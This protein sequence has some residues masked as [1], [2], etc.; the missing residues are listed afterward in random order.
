MIPQ[1]KFE[2]KTKRGTV[3]H[4]NIPLNNSSKKVKGIEN[5]DEEN[6]NSVKKT[7]ILHNSESSSHKSNS[8]AESSSM[9]QKNLFA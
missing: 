5:H 3:L 2:T 8:G 4:S 9:E 7:S 6:P 1:N